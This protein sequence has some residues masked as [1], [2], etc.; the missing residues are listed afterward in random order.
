[1][2]FIKNLECVF[3]II[4]CPLT[5][6]L[7]FFVIFFFLDLK[8]IFSVLPLVRE[9]LFALSQCTIFF[10]S[11][12]MIWLIFLKD[13]CPYNK[14]VLSAKWCISACSVTR[15]ISLIYM[16]NNRGPSLDPGGTPD[17]TLRVSEVELLRW[18]G[19]YFSNGF[20]RDLAVFLKHHNIL[21]LICI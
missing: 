4:F 2:C 12:F 18:I 19:S 14:L 11:K 8:M 6:K 16:T 7:R 3:V 21:I 1:M 20:G 5:R 15:C 10:I 13:L 9:I 17:L